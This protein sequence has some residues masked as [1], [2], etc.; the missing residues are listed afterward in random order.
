M[1]MGYKLCMQKT[2]N[3]LSPC[4]LLPTPPAPPAPCFLPP[5]PCSLLPL[6]PAS[7]YNLYG[8]NTYIFI[9]IPV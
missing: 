5:A 2:Q 8:D 9:S 3:S 1:G 7:C 4:S 6:L